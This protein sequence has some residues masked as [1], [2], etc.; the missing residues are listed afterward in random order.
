DAFPL[1]PCVNTIMGHSSSQS[2]LEDNTSAEVIK[3]E[4]YRIM[5]L[6]FYPAHR[7][8]LRPRRQCAQPSLTRPKTE[9]A[10]PP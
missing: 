10:C 1:H 4:A 5:R 6:D 7:L 3:E 2:E 9:L 8:Q